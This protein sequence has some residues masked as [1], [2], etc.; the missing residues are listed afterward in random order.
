MKIET[1]V[2]D[3]LK[4]MIPADA[5]KTILFAN[6]ADTSYELFFYCMLADGEFHQC[7]TLAE[8][9]VLDSHLLDLCFSEIASQIKSDE[10]YRAGSNNVFT[11]V[12]DH[13]GVHLDVEYY[14]RNARMYKIKKD[15]KAKYLV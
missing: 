12:A 9:G 14:E 1:L 7:Y 10:K 2:F 5:S 4:K 15:W 8:N 3:N 13:S 11:F 6:V